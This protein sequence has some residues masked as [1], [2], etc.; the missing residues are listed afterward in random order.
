[1]KSAEAIQRA[2]ETA[3]GSRSEHHNLMLSMEPGES[4]EHRQR[5]LLMIAQATTAEVEKWCH[6]AIALR[7][8]EDAAAAET[9]ASA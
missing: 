4:G 5:T 2:I 1:V 7:T 6:L 3:D 8:L 9:A